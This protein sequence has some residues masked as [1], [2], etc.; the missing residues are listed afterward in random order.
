M[1]TPKP[2]LLPTTDDTVAVTS[3]MSLGGLNYSDV[4]DDEADAVAVRQCHTFDSVLIVRKEL[5]L[6]CIVTCLFL[7]L[8]DLPML[9]YART[10]L[11]M[12]WT[13]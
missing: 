1:P 5:Q 9:P 3:A 8:F 6:S 2:T 4:D 13:C 11:A 12:K 7:T 10:D